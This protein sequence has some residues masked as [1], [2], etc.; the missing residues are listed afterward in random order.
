MA[1]IFCACSVD[2]H[3]PGT[4]ISTWINRAMKC[5]LLGTSVAL[6]G[7]KTND[8]LRNT[9]LSE[10]PKVCFFPLLLPLCFL[11]L[12]VMSFW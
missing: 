1:Q 8:E 4:N 3:S 10:G 11:P 5:Q 6:C 12:S 9:I 7:P 2:L